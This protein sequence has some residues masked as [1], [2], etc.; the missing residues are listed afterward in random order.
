MGTERPRRRAP[1]WAKARIYTVGHSTRS[2]EELVELLQAHGI[3]TLVDIRTVPRSRTNPQFNR[4]TLPRTLARADIRYVHMARLGGLRRA[5]ADSPN[6]AWRNASFRGY[7]D[8]MLTDEF[9]RGLEELRELTPDGPLAL[10]CAEAVRWRCHRSLVA[11]AL[12]A[13]GVEVRHI[14]SRTRAEPHKLTPFARL[15]GRQVLYPEDSTSSADLSA[16]SESGR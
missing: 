9:T 14:T 15:H 12:F 3:Q 7:A 16:P 5:R 13:R 2:A 1:G 11:D 10:M 8:Y 4:D 6:G